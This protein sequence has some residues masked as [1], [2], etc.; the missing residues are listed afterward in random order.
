MSIV[1]GQGF[2]PLG[3]AKIPTKRGTSLEMSIHI[4]NALPP[5]S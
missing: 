1:R 4:A 3:S 5:D 2:D